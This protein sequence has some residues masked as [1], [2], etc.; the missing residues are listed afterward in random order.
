[1]GLARVG[2][3]LSF[4]AGRPMRSRP[5]DASRIDCRNRVRDFFG[6][7]YRACM[8]SSPSLSASAATRNVEI[9][10]VEPVRSRDH[11]FTVNWSV[12]DFLA[13]RRCSI[14][15]AS[16]Q[17]SFQGVS[18]SSPGAEGRLAS[19]HVFG[20]GRRWRRI[21]RFRLA[22]YRLMSCR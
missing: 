4:A 14:V 13:V 3:D 21:R 7:E 8:R 6:I 11:R 17:S 15:M 10:D 9:T 5:S 22:S 20:V 1:M 18:A 2:F 16:V 19:V 12:G